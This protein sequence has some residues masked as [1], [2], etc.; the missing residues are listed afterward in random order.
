MVTLTTNQKNPFTDRGTETKIP[1]LPA[2]SLQSSAERECIAKGGKWDPI[3]KVCVMPQINFTDVSKKP[4]EPEVKLQNPEIF[5]SSETG[6]LSGIEVPN[7]NTYLGLGPEEVNKIAES[8]SQKAAIPEGTALAGTTKNTIQ[9]QQTIQKLMQLTQQGLLTSN[10]L[11]VIAGAN[12]DLKEALGAGVVSAAPGIVA[13]AV[14]GATVGALGG[15]IGIVGGAII[16]GIGSF[17]IGLRGNLKAQQSGEFAADQTALTKGERYL[18]GLI[19]DTNQNPQNAAE[20]IALF[21]QTLNLIDA[22][23]A[24]TYKDSQENLNRFL[25][26]DGTPQLA[27][28]ET[29][30]ATMRQY[31][32]SQFTSAL[33]KPNPNQIL[34]SAEDLGLESE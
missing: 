4:V 27:K 30:D 16:G 18:R 24:K 1:T 2:E 6:R 34:L 3:N 15:P 29:F 26:N 14:T 33:N 31:Y 19:T 11:D 25:G 10:E 20:N 13:G 17:L 12:P 5:K 28:F 9:Q 23:H 8:E 22:A 21:Y 7:G 32:I